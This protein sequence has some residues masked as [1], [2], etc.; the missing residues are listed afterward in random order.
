MR[1]I[2]GH[3]QGYDDDDGSTPAH[4]AAA[5][6]A[7]ATDRSTEPAA[8]AALVGSRLLVPVVAVLGEVEYDEQGRPHDKTSEMA[9]VLLKR[10]DGQKALLAFTSMK[11]MAAWDPQARPVPVSTAEACRSA[12]QEE[13]A[14]VVIDIAGP[15]R[16][17]I[18]GTDLSAAA[19]GLRLVGL[20]DGRWGW[21][22]VTDTEIDS[23]DADSVNHP[24]A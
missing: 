21:L 8:L 18:D 3:T 15:V 17:V 11:S 22:A 19:Q 14:A 7:F 5:L 24:P 13:A 2:D 10:A 12:L 9:A 4:V 6:S 16:F 1:S 23:F 20:D